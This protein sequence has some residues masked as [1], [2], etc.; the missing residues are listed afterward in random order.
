ML[1]LVSICAADFGVFQTR[2]IQSLLSAFLDGF[3]LSQRITSN[4][5]WVRYF[6]EYVCYRTKTG[7]NSKRF[8]ATELGAPL[9]NHL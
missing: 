9:K 4:G 1:R 7:S 8:I 3:C 6:E 5:F 2:Q